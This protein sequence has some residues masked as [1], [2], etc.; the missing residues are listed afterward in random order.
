M[1][2]IR[3]LPISKCIPNMRLAK[4]IYN[5]EGVVL[6]SVGFE[7][8]QPILNRLQQSGVDHL[9]IHDPRTEDVEI[10]EL[11]SPETRRMALTNVRFHFRRMMD[12]SVKQRGLQQH[13]GKDFRQ[14][15]E[16]MI[17]DLNGHKDAM[18]MLTHI[19]TTDLY[20]YHH[21]VNVCTY[22]IILGMA[23]G[24][25]QD[26]LMV[27]GL[28]ALLHD[29]GKTEVPI[30]ILRKPGALTGEEFEIVKE[31]A[32]LGYKLL[33]DEPNIPLLS[34]HCAFQ[35]HERIDGSGYPRGIKGKDIHEYAKWLGITDSFDA[36]T[37]HRSYRAAML[38][39]QALEGLF[40]G[41]G[42]LYDLKMLEYF[43]DRIAVYPIG[44]T[45]RLHSGEEGVV[46]DINSTYPH[47]PIVRIIQDDS[48]REL[49]EPYEVDL[50][51]HLSIMIVDVLHAS[52]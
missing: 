39:H 18:V 9:Y 43:R 29:I 11:L 33:K 14:V 15:L 42:T 37:T 16:A 30:D 8:T 23:Y 3:L 27:L 26:E 52:R 5:E 28:G 47:R 1:M 13:L 38:P 31:H 49:R 50:S 19:N 44:I 34:A 21:S 46:V 12:Q 4:T 7:L 32:F 6:L 24:Y 36:M 22:T 10:P 17:S 2:T 40:A 41:A 25:S 51:K 20:L 48:G 35:H 45:V